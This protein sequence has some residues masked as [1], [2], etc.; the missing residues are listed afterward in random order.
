MLSLPLIALVV[1]LVA[2][3]CGGDDEAGLTAAN[4]SP[5]SAT[6]SQVKKVTLRLAYF[7]N[8]THANPLIGVANGTYQQEL[9]EN[10]KLEV[11]TFNAGPAQID[12][13]FTGEIDAG[14]I[15]PNPA[16]NGYQK[17]NGEALRVIS[18]GASGGALLIVRPEANITKATDLA[19]KKI[20]TPQLGN[21]QDVA[22]RA[23]VLAAG[24]KTK[25]TGGNVTILP[26]ANA[27]TLTLFKQGSIDGAWVPEPW[28]TRLILEA[29][30][31]VFL[32]E[33]T[34]WPDGKFVTTNLIV[35]T[36]FLKDNPDAVERLLRAVVKTSLYI[37]ANADASKK[38]VNDEIKR[39]TSAGLST[40]VID[41]AWK[42]LDFTYDPI[43]SSLKKSA[44][45]A[46]KLGFLGDKAPQLSKIYD[47]LLLNN[48]LAELKLPAVKE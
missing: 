42:N 48:V 39:I 6:N 40:E 41:G 7:P 33:K 38:L 30:G 24:L 2:L 25:E 28:A 10:V 13:L 20:A 8:I 17:S 31:K 22:L 1:G 23:Y 26:T 15:G 46:F 11:K 19:N 27:D 4:G 32:D 5:A 36:K 35:S 29:G 16:I 12:A 37:A 14:F 9:G 47:L 44:D 34:L 43:T 21:T 3:A 45:D 18:G